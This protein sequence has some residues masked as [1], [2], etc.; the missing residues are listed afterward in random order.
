MKPKCPN[1]ECRA[2]LQYVT[3]DYVYHQ[4]DEFYEEDGS[5]DFSHR[6]D[7][8]VDE[9]FEDHWWCNTC[10]KEFV[11]KEK[12]FILKPEVTPSTPSLRD[13]GYGDSP[14]VIGAPCITEEVSQLCP[15]C[16]CGKLFAVEVV[17]ENP[18]RMLR[19]PNNHVAVGRYVGCPACPWASPMITTARPKVSGNEGQELEQLREVLEAGA[20]ALVVL[21]SDPALGP[22]R[23]EAWATYE[24]A[25]NTR[26]ALWPVMLAV[27]EACVISSRG[28]A[29]RPGV[30]EAIDALDDAIRAHFGGESCSLGRV[31]SD[32]SD[33]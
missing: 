3:R 29:C 7:S 16:G 6:N 30:R 17:V 32:V 4:V 11:Y 13:Y 25:T 19:V 22:E 9:E 31:E 23:T 26:E 8:V 20:K 15:N 28:R 18:P 27:I 21:R 5:V 33:E 2:N 24:R 12:K 10:C 1:T 14:E